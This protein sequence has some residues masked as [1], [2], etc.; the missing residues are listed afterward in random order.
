MPNRSNLLAKNLQSAAQPLVSIIRIIAASIQLN[1]HAV[2]VAS[3]FVVENIPFSMCGCFVLGERILSERV[4][5]VAMLL[6][7][8]R[9]DPIEM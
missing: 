8:E 4:V 5:V 7:G 2:P 9:K 3:A 6:L 1:Q